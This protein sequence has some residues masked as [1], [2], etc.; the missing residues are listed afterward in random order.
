M[1]F[2]PNEPIV[3]WKQDH[4]PVQDLEGLWTLDWKIG[5]R[6]LLHRFYT[7]IDQIF[8]IWAGVT[9]VIFAT[10]QFLPIS[11]TVQAI[12]WTAL[13]AFGT[14]C[15]AGFTWFWVRVEKLRWLVYWWA[16]L[17]IG[18]AVLTDLSIFLG[19]GQ[20]LMRLC[21]LWLGLTALGYIGTGLGM[22]SRSFILAGIF[23]LL[24]IIILPFFPTWQFLITGTIVGIALLLLAELQ[25]DMRETV[26]YDVLTPEQVEFNYQQRRLCKLEDRQKV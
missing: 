22:R 7:R 8:L 24:G 11:W 15:M 6:Q 17:M 18:G 20:I 5:N 23:H 21:P 1:T 26:D 2:F 12:C 10:A 13:T 9:T 19:W 25:W 3:R 14:A 4:L 16:I